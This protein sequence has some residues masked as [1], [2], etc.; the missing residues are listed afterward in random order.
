MITNWE[1]E[2]ICKCGRM[3]RSRHGYSPSKDGIAFYVP[4]S[5]DPLSTIRCVS[6]SDSDVCQ[7]CGGLL[8][9]YSGPEE[10]IW[11]RVARYKKVKTPNENY[12][13]WK[14]STWPKNHTT[15]NHEVMVDGTPETRETGIVK[16]SRRYVHPDEQ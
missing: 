10:Q 1:P 16:P 2:W 14:P 12:V 15:Y 5:L 8:G 11:C 9:Q 13:W 4:L 3:F 7:S 6:F